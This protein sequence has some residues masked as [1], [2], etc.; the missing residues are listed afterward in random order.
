MWWR[1]PY[2]T[3]EFETSKDEKEK[4]GECSGIKRDVMQLT[5]YSGKLTNG[6]GVGGIAGE[7]YQEYVRQVLV[8]KALPFENM[9]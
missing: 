7:V 1:F 9:C 5:L 6:L 8:V 2:Y 3:K 4:N